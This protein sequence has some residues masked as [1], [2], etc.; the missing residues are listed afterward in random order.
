MQRAQSAIM[1]SL[2]KTKEFDKLKVVKSINKDSPR[3]YTQTK[4]PT[5]QTCRYSGS[6]HPPRQCLVYGK[7]CTNCS[8]IGH[9]RTVCRSRRA[10]STNEVEQE[11]AQDSA[12][13][14]SIDSVNI[15]SI[16]INKNCSLLTVNLKTS[17]DSNNV[18]VP[19]KVDMGGDGNIMPL[20]IYKNFSIL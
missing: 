2:T 15:N 16:Y 20:Y 8:K 12:E 9:F 4:M 1:N 19:Y 14:S 11:T 5:K 7:R 13:E 18:M 17:A 3:R 6:S 10:Q